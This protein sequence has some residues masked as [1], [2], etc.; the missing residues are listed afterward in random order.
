LQVAAS[1][2]NLIKKPFP[3]IWLMG[4]S[5][6][7]KTTLAKELQNHFK[8]K[9]LAV[10]LLDGDDLR[11]GL[12]KNLGF[13]ENDR[14]ENLRRAAEVSKLFQKSE[15]ICI[16]AFISPT[17]AAQQMIREIVGKNYF[18]VYVR[19]SLETCE[20]RDVKGLYKKARNGEIPNFTGI[21]ADFEEP[22]Y[23]TLEVNTEENSIEFCLNKILS[24]LESFEPLADKQ[25][26]K[27]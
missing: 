7:G 23:A 12:N 8:Q 2:L 10:A 26:A 19:C 22:L 15:I 27:N 5:G 16:C 25:M 11:N 13:S 24:N 20:K 9:G 1:N 4:F 3:V 14:L 6:S 21:S 17:H 18:E